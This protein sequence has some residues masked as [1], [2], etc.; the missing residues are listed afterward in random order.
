M[1]QD[2]VER[3]LPGRQPR[4]VSAQPVRFPLMALAPAFERC[5]SRP[6]LVALADCFL[7]AV[8]QCR[9]LLG[10]L[11]A[12]FPALP[13]LLGGGLLPQPLLLG[14]P[15]VSG[16]EF[17]EFAKTAAGFGKGVQKRR[18][19]GA[20]RLFLRQQRLERLLLVRDCGIFRLQAFLHRGGCGMR[21]PRGLFALAHLHAQAFQAP[22]YV[23][24]VD[25]RL[26][27]ARRV[28]RSRA[29]LLF[30][31]RLQPL[32]IDGQAGELLARRLDLRL[33][34]PFVAAL[35]GQFALYRLGLR[36]ALPEGVFRRLRFG[37]EAFSMRVHAAETAAGEPRQRLAEQPAV[38]LETFRF[39]RLALE[40]IG[41]PNDLL[42]DI[43][44]AV[45]IPSGVFELQLRQP[46]P[47]FELGDP[48]GLFHERA[49]VNR[50]R[51]QDL[52]DAPLLDDR[53]VI[54]AEPRAHEKIVNVAQANRLAVQ[55]VTAL[56]A[57]KQ[58]AG[59][60]DL[61]RPRAPRERRPV[62]VAP[63]VERRFEAGVGIEQRQRHR[64][65]SGR[66][67]VA[68]AIENHVVHA[69]AAQRLRR[70]LAEHPTDCVAD[71]RFAA[72]VWPDHR[73]N[74]VAGEA[75]LLAVA[76]RFEAEQ[77]D[78]FELQQRAL[79]RTI[80]AMRQTPGDGA[81]V[82]LRRTFN[83]ALHRDQRPIRRR[84]VIVRVTQTSGTLQQDF[85]AHPQQNTKYRCPYPYMSFLVNRL[86]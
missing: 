50:S 61:A 60:R 83:R 73:R 35:L 46:L 56:P 82:G 74:A 68:R 42:Q 40:G 26:L 34:A 45:E 32:Y 85:V 69:P 38:F 7:D 5:D 3:L 67:A 81:R 13:Q 33:P 78:F 58:L 19:P 65:Q 79:P 1:R 27:L 22:A 10:K 31:A 28:L 64:R 15:R 43:V 24:D 66:L 14:Q 44:D 23:G 80:P 84:S 54:R 76:E 48:G 72:A 29:G 21:I 12:A 59:D 11:L 30:D 36:I 51:A 57:A 77:L 20:A 39:R 53:V 63:A 71:I 8:L 70:L 17:L 2:L 37:R 16:Q 47:R 6:Q 62:A 55:Q 4:N 18:G 9:G 86:T 25:F 49:P 75:Q 41:L 52:P